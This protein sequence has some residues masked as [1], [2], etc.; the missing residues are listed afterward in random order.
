[1]NTQAI[2]NKVGGCLLGGIIGDA[3]G[4]PVES[5]DY[6]R[7]AA[8]KGTIDNFDGA[9]TDDS[10]IKLILCEAL[11]AHGGHITADEFAQ[12]FMN[13][14]QD[15]DWFYV[16]VRNMYHK[17]KDGL[18]L[19]VNAGH[20]NMASSSSAMSISPMGILNACDPRSAASEA[21]EVAGLIHSGCCSFCRDA[22]SAM[23]AAVA[24]A[25]TRGAT[26]ESVL[27][28]STAY[29]H[30]QSA[31][32]MR[33]H[34]EN[35]LTLARQSGGY[36]AFRQ[37]YYETVHL[38]NTFCDSR[39]TVPVA[40]ALFYLSGGD[41]NKAIEYGANF[42]RDADTIATMAGAVGGA[43]AGMDALRPQWVKKVLDHNSA[44]LVLA[45]QM[46]GLVV[47]RYEEKKALLTALDAV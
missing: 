34:I 6:R 16:P 47:K 22:A 45:D 28:A 20:D 8:E 2:K 15:Y 21:Y 25:F 37:S 24:A 39:E 40:L 4:A 43:F 12:S 35:A 32:V 31:A 33:T 1:M 30:A 5:W 36:E 11:L 27:E 10:I 7:I 41:V 13:H 17:I 14:P 44:Q 42:G 23:A 29:L 18:D 46:T 19:P 26:V 38:Y 9:G 3:M